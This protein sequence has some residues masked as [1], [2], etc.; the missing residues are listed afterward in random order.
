MLWPH[1]WCVKNA[2]CRK[3]PTLQSRLLA[4][5]CAALIDRRVT[6]R[7]LSLATAIGV[8]VLATG[9]C[10]SPRGPVAS[11]ASLTAPSSLTESTSDWAFSGVIV[12]TPSG[13][14][15]VGATVSATA[16]G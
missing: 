2:L 3:T 10:D 6:R 16:D 13:A 11:N 14:P 4:V 15:V 7:F 9:A 1:D 8:I 5:R 12:E